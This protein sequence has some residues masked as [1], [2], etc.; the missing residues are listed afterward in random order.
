ME[1]SIARRMEG[2]DFQNALYYMYY[3]SYFGF[4]KSSL[5]RTTGCRVISS[6]KKLASSRK[7]G[8]TNLSCYF[9]VTMETKM[10]PR[11]AS[12]SSA[13]R[14]ANRPIAKHGGSG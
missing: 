1:T 12:Q 13:L 6:N 10:R 7:Q 14:D 5:K 11:T 8:Q 4:G 3:F 2:D 9:A